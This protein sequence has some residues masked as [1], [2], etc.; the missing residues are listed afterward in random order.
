[1][2]LLA[3]YEVPRFDL[4]NRLSLLSVSLLSLIAVM[5]ESRG[6]LPAVKEATYTDTFLILYILMSML[7][8]A[9]IVGTADGYSGHLPK[10]IDQTCHFFSAI[11][12]IISTIALVIK[13]IV[14]SKY[15]RS[16]RPMNKKLEDKQVK[17][18]DEDW[19]LDHDA[20]HEEIHQ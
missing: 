10:Y 7:P 17:A 16:V 1:M 4:N 8:L 12:I 20:I 18:P 5:Q 14:Y 6:D 9:Y 19:I 11:I 13:Y 3:V 2:F 15:L